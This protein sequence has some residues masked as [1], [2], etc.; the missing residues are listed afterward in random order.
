[1]TLEEALDWADMN[2]TPEATGDLHNKW[3]MKTLADE[4]RSMQ[5]ADEACKEVETALEGL[6]YKGTY[7]QQ[8]QQM[9][10]DMATPQS[11]VGVRTVLFDMANELES[12]K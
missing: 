2:F 12:G 3:V 5:G 9:R 7:A 11:S 10:L 6:P 1:M 4:V 8:I